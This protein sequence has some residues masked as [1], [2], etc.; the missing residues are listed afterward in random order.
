MTPIYEKYCKFLKDV[1]GLELKEGYYWMDGV[2]VKGFNEHNILCKLYRI[3]IQD[4][5]S[6]TYTKYKNKKNEEDPIIVPWSKTL[7]LNNDHLNEIENE[8]IQLLKKYGLNTDRKIIDTNST[9]KDSEV[10]TYI[11]HKAGLDFTTYFN[12]TTMDV[13]ESTCMAKDKGYEFTYPDKKYGGFYQWS[14]KENLIPTRLNRSCCTYFKEGATMNA[15]DKNDKMLFLFGMRNSEST[16]RSGYTDEWVN[17][18][19]G[20]RDWLG[21]LPIRKWNDLD[22]WLY[23]MRENIDINEKYKMGYDRV[24]CSVICPNYSKSTWV[25]DKYWY[26]FLFNR[27]RNDYLKDDFIRNNKWLIM[28]CTVEEYI[29]VAWNGGVYRSEPTEDVIKEYAEHN[30]IDVNIARKYFNRYCSNGCLNNRKTLQKIKD[31][32]CLAMN[33][34]LFGRQIEKFKCKKCLLKELNWTKEKWDEEVVKF[35]DQGCQL[36]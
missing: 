8:A 27:W 34:K 20:N 14:K 2:I 24:G 3:K 36:F 4:D 19:W 11:A 9:G 23:I 25:L 33:M 28:N 31:K 17:E 1:C 10:K 29:Q 5:L 6:V 21:I 12:V 16:N 32:E 35:K 13:G 18:K 15:F 30:D 22:I 26:P 7:E